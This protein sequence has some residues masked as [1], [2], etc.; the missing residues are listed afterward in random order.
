MD[1]QPNEMAKTEVRRMDTLWKD[2]RRGPTPKVNNSLM[3][4][5]RVSRRC[6]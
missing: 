3:S 2:E 1:L 4:D 5:D 6:N